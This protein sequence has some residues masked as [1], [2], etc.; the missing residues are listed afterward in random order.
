MAVGRAAVLL[1]VVLAA[2]CSSSHPTAAPSPSPTTAPPPN[3]A[4]LATARGCRPVRAAIARAAVHAK[5]LVQE[6]ERITTPAPAQDYVASHHLDRT[7]TAAAA[8]E[9]DLDAA[10]L[11]LRQD[12][13][14]GGY[15]TVPD[16]P[17]FSQLFV[18]ACRARAGYRVALVSIRR[19][20]AERQRLLTLAAH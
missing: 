8:L 17:T 16:L 10:V 11:Q 20:D 6:R 5:Q 3:F 18:D 2:G 19:A 1:G 15:G 9:T 4:P 14:V 12:A 7:P 13:A